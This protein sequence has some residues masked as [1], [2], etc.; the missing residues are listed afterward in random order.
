MLWKTDKN[1]QSAIHMKL[2]HLPV[3]YQL[4]RTNMKFKGKFNKYLNILVYVPKGGLSISR[5]DY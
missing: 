3:S 2:Y 5:L 4:E 1:F